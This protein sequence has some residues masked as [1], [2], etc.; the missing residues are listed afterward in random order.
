[1]ETEME[2]RLQCSSKKQLVLLVQELTV[3]HPELLSEIPAILDQLATLAEDETEH[4][5]DHDSSSEQHDD[6]WDVSGELATMDFVRTP[7][8]PSIDLA[9]YRQRIEGYL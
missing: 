2:R 9:A 1:M 4:G 8:F 5:N 7:E 3:Q 6:E